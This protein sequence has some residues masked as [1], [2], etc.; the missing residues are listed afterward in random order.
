MDRD[1]TA[2]GLERW[3][4]FLDLAP[5][6]RIPRPQRKKKSLYPVLL[7]EQVIMFDMDDY[8]AAMAFNDVL[9]QESDEE[10]K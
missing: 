5:C 8:D 3:N 10:E 6:F 2:L 9:R 1:R 4:D 7:D